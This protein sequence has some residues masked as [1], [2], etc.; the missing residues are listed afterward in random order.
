M[1][2]KKSLGTRIKE[3]RKQRS[4]SQEKL[5]ELVEISQNALSYIETG[6]N[7]CTAETL[8]K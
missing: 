1:D 5:A 4:L 8:E 3:L 6:D 7:F 2:I